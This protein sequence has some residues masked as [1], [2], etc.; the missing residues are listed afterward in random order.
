MHSACS[1]L[2]QGV[3]GRVF[4]VQACLPSARHRGYILWDTSCPGVWGRVLR[5]QPKNEGSYKP[6]HQHSPVVLEPF[7]PNNLTNVL[8]ALP[9]SSPRKRSLSSPLCLMRHFLYLNLYGNWEIVAHLFLIMLPKNISNYIKT[10]KKSHLNKWREEWFLLHFPNEYVIIGYKRTFLTHNMTTFCPCEKR[11][12][13]Y[14]FVQL[15]GLR[16]LG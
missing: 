6:F 3:G 2:G 14:S 12:D 8:W 16:C 15:S 5:S 1:F 4:R 13:L 10:T 9:D 7:V 11:W